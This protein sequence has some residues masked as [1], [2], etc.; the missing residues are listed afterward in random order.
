MTRTTTLASLAAAMLLATA[1]T[2]GAVVQPDHLA[3]QPSLEVADGTTVR[4]QRAVS[5]NRV[6]PRALRAW[7][8]FL[9]AAGPDWQAMWDADTGIPTRIFGRGIAAPD[10]VESADAAAQHARAFLASHLELLA[11]G[12]SLSDFV[13]VSNHLDRQTGLRTVG[14]FQYHDGLRVVGGQVSVRFK[15]D[16]LFVIGSEALPRVEGRLPSTPVPERHARSVATAWVLTD[17]AATARD[18]DY[19][20]AMILPLVS[21]DRVEYRTV[22]KVTVDARD[23][24]GRWDVYVD[25]SSGAPVAREQ[26]LR[27]ATGSV[28]YNVPLRYPNADRADLPAAGA[29]VVIDGATVNADALGGVTW[30][31][32]AAGSLTARARGALVRVINDAG[33]ENTYMTTIEPEGQ[34]IWN[35]ADQPLIDAQITTFIH[36]A[37]V[38]DYVRSFAPDLEYL[39]AE[40]RATVNIDDS[41]NAFSDG[42]TIN[43]FQSSQ[44]CENTGRLAD[45]VYHEFGHSLHAQSIVPGVGA[46]DGAFSEGLSD[47]LAATIV[48]DPGMGRGFFYD[49]TALRH[50]DPPDKEHV[51]PDDVGQIHYTGIIFAG[52]MWDL[53]KILVDRYGYDE[54][55]ELSDRLFYA[56]V[57]RASDIPTTY[58]EILAADDDNGD[59]SDGTPNFCDINAA[60]GAHGLRSITVEV[61]PLAVEPPTADGYHVSLRV[62]GLS[63]QCAGDAVSAV[64]LAWRQRDLSDSGTVEMTVTDGM[65]EGDIPQQPDGTVVNYQVKLEFED[66]TK[67][68]FPD[69]AADPWYEFFVGEV[70]ELYCNDFEGTDPFADGWTHALDMG[71]ASE[72]ADDWQWGVPAGVSGSGDPRAAWSGTRVIGND[73][74]GDDFNGS[75]QAD[76]VN[77]ATS[78]AIDVGKYTDVR[79]QYWRWLNVED[80][81]FDQGSVY[82]N[83][84][85]AW[86]N[87]NSDQGNSSS[88]HH[89]D[90]E[91]RFHDIPASEFIE[92]GSVQVKFEIA[93]DGGL[94][95]GGWTIDDFCVVAFTNSVC[96]DGEITG[97]E[98]CDDGEGNANEP[99]ACR[100]TCQLPT[101][102]DG[103][104]DSGEECDDGDGDDGNECSNSCTVGP[105][106][107]GDGGGCGCSSSDTGAGLGM[108]L[109]LALVGLVT[110]R[111][112][113]V[114]A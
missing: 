78:P 62:G 43:F 16:R 58:V 59:L 6:P 24:I 5:W 97:A 105:G 74:G 19:A 108:L 42:E 86:Q 8:N 34:A 63:D 39:D 4:N 89:A 91:W 37:I 50:M 111:T 101:C 38:K 77:S 13:M 12:A 104:I 84:Q 49:E 17:A 109:L 80:A 67:R 83:N 64:S 93:S 87:L 41:C 61:N 7:T 92:D 47:Y 31:G 11:P 66:G 75:Y 114:R 76:K 81:F 30:A 113:R 51:W 20:G 21:H 25:A 72:G 94:E 98:T 52:A 102:G 45:V 73:L 32:T 14:F 110:R 23:P 1:G 9:N 35:A 18:L 106:F 28:H 3:G 60:F 79:V 71:E 85:L 22:V 36:S 103:I 95:M 88:T 99:D 33:S 107:E 29:S 10:A 44:Q 53:R 100:E 82:V 46:F 26:T 55:V 2:A 57:Q 56:A 48:D 65:Y 15:N 68:V 112:L 70:V 27:F 69:N 96:G 40:L 90:K 54:G